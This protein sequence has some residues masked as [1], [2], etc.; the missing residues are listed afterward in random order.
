MAMIGNSAPSLFMAQPPGVREQYAAEH[1]GPLQKWDADAVEEWIARHP[2]LC[3]TTALF[4]G[5]MVGWFIKR[6]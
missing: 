2:V 6:R 4:I 5:A 3:V 1:G